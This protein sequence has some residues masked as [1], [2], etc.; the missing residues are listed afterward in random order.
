MVLLSRCY[1]QDSAGLRPW[2]KYRYRRDMVTREKVA[3]IPE[4]RLCLICA[5]V[6]RNKGLD[7]KYGNVDAFLSHASSPQHMQEFHDFKASVAAWIKEH[8]K[9]KVRLDKAGLSAVQGAT[10]STSRKRA[11]KF[12]MPKQ[13][14][15]A[16]DAWN[17][18]LYGPLP[19]EK[20]VQ[21]DIDGQLITGIWRQTGLSG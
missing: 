8:N 2:A 19:Q 9:G 5:N 4:G 10:L 11:G 15:V 18:D 7:F 1:G 13:Q 21:E 16:I 14:F 20:V 17:A 12:L 6:F 3:R